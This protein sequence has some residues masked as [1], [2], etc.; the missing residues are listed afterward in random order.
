MGEQRIQDIVKI[1]VNILKKDRIIYGTQH[2]GAFVLFIPNHDKEKIEEIVNETQKA[3]DDY[4]EAINMIQLEL[5][6]GVY[7]ANS[8]KD[9]L[10]DAISNANLT[11]ELNKSGKVLFYSEDVSKSCFHAI[12]F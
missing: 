10:V 12:S 5:Q 3:I 8:L 4:T 2:E 7:C 6:V 1:M 9:S 11:R